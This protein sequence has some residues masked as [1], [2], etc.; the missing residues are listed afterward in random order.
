M[1]ESQPSSSIKHLWK[2]KRTH[3]VT[4]DHVGHFIP[5]PTHPTPLSPPS[6]LNRTSFHDN[7]MK[8]KTLCWNRWQSMTMK[9]MPFTRGTYR[10]LQVAPIQGSLNFHSLASYSLSALAIQHTS[11]HFQHTH[12]A[13]HRE[14][15]TPPWKDPGAKANEW[16]KADPDEP[17]AHRSW[18]QSYTS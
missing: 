7:L 12:N 16:D 6:Q 18:T 1:H 14:H 13:H 2:M 15:V 8:P 10:Q 5:L 3:N 9:N 11:R 17:A 4:L